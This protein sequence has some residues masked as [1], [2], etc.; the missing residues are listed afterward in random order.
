MDSMNQEAEPLRPWSLANN[1]AAIGQGLSLYSDPLL[2]LKSCIRHHWNRRHFRRL[3]PN[4]TLSPRKVHFPDEAGAQYRPFS[5]TDPSDYVQDWYQHFNTYRR[6][7][8]MPPHGGN[9]I[10][11]DGGWTKFWDPEDPRYQPVHQRLM[12]EFY[13]LQKLANQRRPLRVKYRYRALP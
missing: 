4:D 9:D 5:P 3:G 1:Q 8:T 13:R 12:L 7:R 2:Q 10:H 11:L 6:I